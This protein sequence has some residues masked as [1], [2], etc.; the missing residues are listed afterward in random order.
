[1]KGTADK[2]SSPWHTNLTSNAFR[3]DERLLSVRLDLGTSGLVIQHSIIVAFTY[4][5]LR[6]LHD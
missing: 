5:V 6:M 4:V 1:M 3:S 2:G